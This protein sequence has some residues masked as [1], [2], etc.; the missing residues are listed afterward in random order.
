MQARQRSRERLPTP[1][2]LDRPLLSRVLRFS[3]R[4]L[5]LGDHRHYRFVGVDGTNRNRWMIFL[6]YPKDLI[7]ER[8]RNT[9]YIAEIENDF[10]EE[11]RS[12][13]DPSGLR[14]RYQMAVRGVCTELD[15]NPCSGKAYF[16][17]DKPRET[18]SRCAGASQADLHEDSGS[19]ES[20][21]GSSNS[22]SSTSDA[23]P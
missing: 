17:V 3:E 1:V 11:V 19:F 23:L 9:L 21:P 15:E 16:V 13:H 4:P 12:S 20:S 7:G 18:P 22:R 8:W 6:E 2:S 14:P 10:L 5:C